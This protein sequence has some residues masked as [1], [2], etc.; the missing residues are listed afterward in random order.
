M[1]TAI[2]CRTSGHWKDWALTQLV[3]FVG[4][5]RCAIHRSGKDSLS[6]LILRLA[7]HPLQRPLAIRASTTQAVSGYKGPLAVGPVG[8]E[9]EA[10]V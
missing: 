6:P 9:A 1:M 10:P 2:T 4:K 3:G 5:I 8:T 7:P